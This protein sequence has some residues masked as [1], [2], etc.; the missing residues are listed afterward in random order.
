VVVRFEGAVQ[1]R[2]VLIAGGHIDSINGR[3]VSGPAPG[4]DDNGTGT[5]SLLEAVRVLLASTRGFVPDVSVEVHFYAGEEGGCVGSEEIAESYAQK[6]VEVVGM[7]ALD[8]TGWSVPWNPCVGILQMPAQTPEC[9]A[10]MQRLVEAYLDVP[11][12]D[13]TCP[14]CIS[15]DSSWIARGYRAC[16]PKEGLYRNFPKWVHTPYDVTRLV[17]YKHMARFTKLTLAWIAEVG[18]LE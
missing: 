16:W 3:N 8:G 11:A 1:P 14:S 6:G 10:M 12:L 13:T 9:T 15:D 2:H 17:N 18:T 4:A 7:M 5:I